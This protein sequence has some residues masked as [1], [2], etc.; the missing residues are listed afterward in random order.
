MAR[1]ADPTQPRTFNEILVIGPEGWL[2]GMYGPIYERQHDGSYVPADFDRQIRPTINVEYGQS[3]LPDYED[4]GMID[5]LQRG[6]IFMGDLPHYIVLVP[7]LTNFV[8]G[9]EAVASEIHKLAAEREWYTI[10]QHAALQPNYCPYRLIPRSVVPR[11]NE[12]LRPRAVEDANAPWDKAKDAEGQPVVGLNQSI[13]DSNADYANWPKEIKVRYS[14]VM[15]NMTILLSVA[16][17]AGEPVYLFSH[18]VSNFF[19]HMAIHVSER[20]KCNTMLVDMMSGL[21]E[22]STSLVLAMGVTCSSNIAQRVANWIVSLVRCKFDAEE[23]TLRSAETNPV[24]IDF[25]EHRASLDTGWN[26]QCLYALDMYTDDPMGVIIG[27]KRTRR[28]VECWT[29]VT[30]GLRLMMAIPVKRQL[31][32]HIKWIGARWLAVGLVIIPLKKR[33][34]TL[35]RLSRLLK[36]SLSCAEHRKL[37]GMLEH[38]RDVLR[39]KANKMVGMYTPFQSGGEADSSPNAQT[40]VTLPM[41]QSAEARVTAVSKGAAASCAVAILLDDVLLSQNSMDMRMVIPTH[42]DACKKGAEVPGMGGCLVEEYWS[43]PFSEEELQMDIPAL[44]LCA[45]AV[46]LIV[47]QHKLMVLVNRGGHRVVAN[48]DAKASPQ[49]LTKQSAKS[50][51]MQAVLN[52]IHKLPVYAAIKH[53]LMVAHVFGEGNYAADCASR[54]KFEELHMYMAQLGHKPSR[55]EVLQEATAFMAEVVAALSRI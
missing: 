23:A 55:I 5:H 6:C 32:V 8:T 27:V 29:S 21:A 54:S 19:Y 52:C 40:V 44:E 50:P 2:P 30:D 33:L 18:D 48:I 20:W 17:E 13:R 49:I 36:G 34:Q 37:N 47:F 41:H 4:R 15:T 9:M 3:I 46:N 45:A 39:L 14:D 10:S 16:I 7:H 22:L 31:G 12:P 1:M 43:Y 42:S 53:S 26:E 51:A 24:L 38:F 28:F 35:D 25:C 11:P